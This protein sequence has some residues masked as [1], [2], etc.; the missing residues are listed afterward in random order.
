VSLIRTQVANDLAGDWVQLMVG[1]SA[2]FKIARSLSRRFHPYRYPHDA[3]RLA[4]GHVLVG[5]LRSDGPSLA[6]GDND[7]PA[8]MA[9]SP[10]SMS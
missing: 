2:K 10:S 9:A 4:N 1:T 5:Y 7:V 3:S 6:S 8:D